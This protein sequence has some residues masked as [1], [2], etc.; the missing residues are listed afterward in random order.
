MAKIAGDGGHGLKTAG[1]RTPPLPGT[2]RVI[3]E[4]E[5][6]HP[7]SKLLQ[8]ELIKS[9]HQFLHTSDTSV[10]TALSVRARKANNWGADIYVSAH[11]NAENHLFDK[12]VDGVETLYRTGSVEGMKLAEYVQAEMVKATGLRDR[13]IKPRSDLGI[14]NLT[15]M[16]AIIVECGFMDNVKDATNMLSVG[17]QSTCAKAIATGINK[18]FGVA[19]APAAPRPIPKA[20]AAPRPIPTVTKLSI[21]GRLVTVKGTNIDGISYIT[22]GTQKIPVRDLFETLG[23]QSITWDNDKQMVVIK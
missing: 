13:G 1:K 2:G 4:W 19:K 14:L 12:F 9:G 15:N 8:A 3:H 16:P 10:D 23:Y 18:Y 5:F 7:T 17:Y 21:S 6:N 11:Y 20:P 22:V